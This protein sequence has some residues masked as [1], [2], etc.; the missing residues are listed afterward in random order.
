MKAIFL[1]I[2]IGLLLF[3]CKK[4]KA[5]APPVPPRVDTTAVPPP[6]LP[7]V[8]T[9]SI[10]A[11]T[12]SSAACGGNVTSEGS[13]PVTFRGVCW[14]TGKDPTIA[15]AKTLNG[16]GTGKFTSA[17]TGLADGGTYYARAYATSS[18]GTSYGNTFIFSA[19]VVG[20]VFQGG[21]LAYLL[22]PSDSGYVA[23]VPHGLV[24]APDDLGRFQWS[25]YVYTQTGASATALGTGNANTATIVTS[26]GTTTSYAARYCA[27][28]VLG[29]HDDW[30]LPSRDELMLLYDAR[31]AI[32][33]FSSSDYYWTSSDQG[34]STAWIQSFI[35]GVSSS[36][37][38]AGNFKVRA[39]RTF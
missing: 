18:A 8:T 12:Q 20:E 28:L 7:V 5:S 33:N 36:Y 29:G 30:Y 11:V 6:Q 25:N 31:N 17:M 16:T 32:R 27:E 4:E 23:T 39:I 1:T 9:D 3:S 19:L 14:S 10:S 26:L 15:D 24:A 35:T 13:S 34:G 2:A 22:K 38:K 21:V 37:D